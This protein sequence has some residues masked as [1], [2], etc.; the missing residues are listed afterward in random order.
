MKITIPGFGDLELTTLILDLNGTIAVHGE[1]IQGVK[2]RIKLI[3]DKGLRVVLLSG[4]TRG[5]GLKMA[6]DLDIELLVVKTKKAKMQA[7][8]K[9]EPKKCVTIGNGR[10]DVSLFKVAR[11]SVAV[12]QAEGVST[13]CI[14]EA[15]ILIPSVV[16]ALDLLIN[17]TGLVST[18]RA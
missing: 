17:E 13:E 16:N 3:K 10:M 12:M 18:L 9:M 8:K 1:I 2:E 15:D 14:R 6:Q 7:A 11:L 5:N 4:D